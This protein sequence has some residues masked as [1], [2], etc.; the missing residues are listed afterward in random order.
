ME[1]WEKVLVSTEFT[2]STHGKFACTDCHGGDPSA[3]TKDA[4][5]EGV[6][7]TLSPDGK[8]KCE[9]C[10]KEETANFDTSLHYSLSGYAVSM[11][12]RSVPEN[13]PALDTAFQN[14]CAD[15]HTSCGDCHVSQPVSVGGG[16]LNGH[17][18]EKTPPMSRTCTACH[19]SR[20]G[21]EY[22]GKHEGIPGD[23]HFRQGRMNCVNCHAGAEL[24]A[25]PEEG[26]GNRYWGMQSPSCANCHEKAAEG[27]DNIGHHS[28]HAEKVECQV[29][30][31]VEYTSCDGCH[32]AIS[33]KTNKPFRTTEATYLTFF[34]GKNPLQS[35]ERP[36][37]YVT[38]RHVPIARDTYSFYGENLLPNFDL[39]PPG[40]YATPNNIQRTTPQTER[41]NKCHGNAEIFLTAD[42]VKEDEVAANKDVIV[43]EP[44]AAIPGQD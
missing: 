37:E 22:L 20:V 18:F 15:C 32:V 8:G 34:I 25:T 11:Q 33:D 42:K 41:C 43:P 40:R 44:P 26:Q 12:S 38:V 29:C 9:M 19:G 13:H 3:D 17:M 31:S 39:A 14:H 27:K 7:R 6:K 16:L 36:Y 28:L 10:H 21:D 4:A 23:V 1:P 5:H 24:H 30:H 35:E 2:S